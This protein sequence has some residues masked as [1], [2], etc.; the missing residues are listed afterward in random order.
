MATPN[1]D[2]LFP[3]LLPDLPECPLDTV[4]MAVRRAC[5]HFCREST[6]WRKLLTPIPLID[7]VH[8]YPLPIPANTETVLVCNVYNPAGNELVGKSLDQLRQILPDWITAEGRPTYFNSLDYLNLTLYPT[9][10]IHYAGTE[11][12]V[13]VALTPTLTAPDL[14]AELTSRYDEALSA[15]A[16]ELLF[17]VAD[18]PWSQPAQVATKHA[19]SERMIVSAR[20][21]VEHERVKGSIRVQSRR[22]GA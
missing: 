14:P 5:R 7:A 20:I 15:G 22:F 17:A 18:R 3:L 2:S 12:T 1:I 21:A 16:L 13:R 4:R 9:P 11:Y 10:V 19:Q 6:A 8:E